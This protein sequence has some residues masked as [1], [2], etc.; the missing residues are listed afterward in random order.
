VIN[1]LRMKIDNI[2]EEATQDME[3]LRKKNKTEMQNKMEGQSR[4]QQ[5]EDRISELEDEMVIKGKTEERLV[6]QLK[7]CEK[8]MQ[9]LTDSIK[10]PN[11]R[12]VCIEGEEVQ[13][14]G[15]SNIFNKI[16]TENFPNLEK[17]MPI[18]GQ[19]ASRTPNRPDR[20][21]TTPRHIIIKTIST[22]TRER[23]LK[24]VREKK[25]IIYK[26]KPI[27][28]T[29]DFSRETL[30][31]RRARGEIF[32][33]LN[34]NSFNPRMLYPA[35]LSLKIDGAIKI[36]HDKQKLKQYVTTKPP[37]QRILQGILRT[38]SETQHNH[39]R[40]GSTKLQ[41]KKKQESRE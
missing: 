36:F 8:K 30:K 34:E 40:A 20:N 38:E 21:R 19:E 1:E 13:E 37:V 28:I 35:K 39:E 6:Q 32:R 2:K 25:Q 31:A 10:R 12:I 23:I 14:K 9:E 29:A 22:E 27:K 15:M 18:Q 26:G 17:I 11:L 16:I 41:E 33:A 7:S 3:N 4:I 5:A 24:A